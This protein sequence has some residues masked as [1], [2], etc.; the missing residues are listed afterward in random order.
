VR[1]AMDEAVSCDFMR[2]L[3][4]PCQTDFGSSSGRVKAKVGY[5]WG[6]CLQWLAFRTGEASGIKDIARFA[7][8]TKVTVLFYIR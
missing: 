5:V 7:S 1:E 4:G 6:K 2:S 8:Q 3:E